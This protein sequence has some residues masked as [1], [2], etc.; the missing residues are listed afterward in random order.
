[1]FGHERLR[2]VDSTLLYQHCNV[3]FSRIDRCVI[4]S[5]RINLGGNWKNACLGLL[6][7][8]ILHLEHI[9]HVQN[10]K[11]LSTSLHKFENP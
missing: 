5:T 2:K 4:L 3:I 6:S 9:L 1:M 7:F 10:K 8:T 11:Q